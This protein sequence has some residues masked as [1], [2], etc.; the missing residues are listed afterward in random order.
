MV[1]HNKCCRI[2]SVKPRIFYVLSGAYMLKFLKFFLYLLCLILL[3][4]YILS[5]LAHLENFTVFFYDMTRFTGLIF[6]Y[7]E[8]GLNFLILTLTFTR[9]SAACSYFKKYSLCSL[10]LIYN[11]TYKLNYKFFL[12]MPNIEYHN[13]KCEQYIKLE[14]TPYVAKEIK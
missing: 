7:Y 3:V 5:T 14:I 1:S 10:S 13:R 4:H 12:R 9:T 6:S 8:I 2:C 11:M